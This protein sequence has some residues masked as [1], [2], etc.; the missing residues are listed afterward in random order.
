MKILAVGTSSTPL[1]LLPSPVQASSFPGHQLLDVCT[2]KGAVPQYLSKK[3]STDPVMLSRIS[4]QS[5]SPDR[6]RVM[7]QSNPG[8]KS[9]PE[10][11]PYS[12]GIETKSGLKCTPRPMSV[13]VGAQTRQ[14]RI[15]RACWHPSSPNEESVGSRLT[16]CQAL[17]LGLTDSALLSLDWAPCSLSC[18]QSWELVR[19]L[20]L[21]VTSEPQRTVAVNLLT[22]SFLLNRH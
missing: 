11:K 4:Q 7:R 18:F 20:D 15:I 19:C 10:H 14:V 21:N 17:S 1:C 22:R 6:S 9:R 3:G 12:S 13:W 2:N 8:R 5:R 16:V